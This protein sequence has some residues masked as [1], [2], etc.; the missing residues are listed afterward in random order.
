MTTLRQ[1][2]ERAAWGAMI[3]DQSRGR[4]TPEFTH[5]PPRKP[6][7]TPTASKRAATICSESTTRLCCDESKNPPTSLVLVHL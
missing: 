1:S 7:A 4:H 6:G 3:G 2:R 5:A